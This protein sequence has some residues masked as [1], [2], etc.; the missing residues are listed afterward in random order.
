MA[1]KTL[2]NI[3]RPGTFTPMGQGAKPVAFTE[4]DLRDAAA[5]YDPAKHRAPIIIG[6]A[7]LAEPAYGH[8]KALSFSTDGLEAEP[9]GMDAQFAEL[10]NKEA[11]PNLSAGWYPPA[12]P[13]N[14]A[15]GH[16]YLHEV[17]FLG[18]VPPAVRGL[19]KPS[20]APAFSADEPGIVRFASEYDDVT[21]AGLWRRLREWVIVKFGIDEA[22]SVI[23]SADV[24]YLEQSAQQEVADAQ[25]EG[26][27]TDSSM[28]G[29]SGANPEITLSEKE[30]A[31]KA[32]NAR[33]LAKLAEASARELAQQETALRTGFAQFAESLCGPDEKGNARLQSKHK[34]IVVDLL[35]L[36]SQ[37][38]ADGGM[39]QFGEGEAK[40][41]AVIVLKE[42]LSSLPPV[43]NFAEQAV[44][45]QAADPIKNPL[46]ADAEHRAEK[47]K[48]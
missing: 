12:H 19:R 27:T 43:L 24:Q 21:N 22:D 32:E 47:A 14:P 36:A 20:F 9:E 11:F 6:H 40:A 33:L 29:F 46:V 48:R 4:S 25:A 3:F 31:L 41:D 30:A 38:K 42:F 8:V 45:G 39:V 7:A 18:A 35:M 28:P 2:L 1:N 34:S 23:P 15:P 5:V 37:P 26:D 13:R 10:V 44:N 17:S 16:W